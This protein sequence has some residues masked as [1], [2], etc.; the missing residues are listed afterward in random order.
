MYYPWPEM[1]RQNYQPGNRTTLQI[2]ST[3]QHS[4]TNG[5]VGLVTYTIDRL[6]KQIMYGELTGGK[7]P[8]GG[9]KLRYYDVIKRDLKDYGIDPMH[10]QTVAEEQPTWL[11]SL[12]CGSAIYIKVCQ[13]HRRSS[14]RGVMLA[15][16]LHNAAN[17]SI[18]SRDRSWPLLYMMCQYFIVCVVSSENV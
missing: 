10:L 18:V 13:I 1:A 6:P 15:I 4:K 5:Y 9:P 17:T 7:R 2:N 8:V 16:N 14:V 3:N 12:T 11:T